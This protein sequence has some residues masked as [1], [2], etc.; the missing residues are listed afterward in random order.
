MTAATIV[1]LIAWL[2]APEARHASD[3][4]FAQ[5]APDQ[6]ASQTG[7]KPTSAP[8]VPPPVAAKPC[9]TA[10]PSTPAAR[11]DCKPAGKSKKRKSSGQTAAADASSGPTRK[12]VSNGSTTDPAPAIS[13]GMTDQQATQ[14]RETTNHLL[15]MT[16]ENLKAIKSRQLNPVQEDTVNQIK[17]YMKQSRDAADSGD[18]QRAYTLAN[19]ARLLSGDLLKH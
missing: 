11:T 3:I 19:K 7:A 8:A 4:A 18:V 17:S 13:P 14:Q 12:V 1:L 6:Q 16:D 15:A 5:T 2:A 10:S 9:S